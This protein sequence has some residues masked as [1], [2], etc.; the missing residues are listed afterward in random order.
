M[1]AQIAPGRRPRPGANRAGKPPIP[2]P[3]P[4]PP[5]H[6]PPPL[7]PIP[8]GDILDDDIDK[9]VEDAVQDEELINL[10]GTEKLIQEAFGIKIG[11]N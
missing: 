3:G 5:P 8:E 10:N 1:P 9:D 2:L 4:L 6:Y 7:A 11:K